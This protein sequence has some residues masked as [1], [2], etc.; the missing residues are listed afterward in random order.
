MSERALAI[1]VFGFEIGAYL[2]IKLR[3][4]AHYL[5]PVLRPQPS[6]LVHEADAVDRAL[7]RTL[8]RLRLNCVIR[9]HWGKSADV[10]LLVMAGIVPF[11]TRS[12]SNR[13]IHRHPSATMWECRNG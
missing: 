1:T 13:D 7:K 3:R 9:A 2:W 8:L 10:P 5:L 4:I 11:C 12:V 6:I